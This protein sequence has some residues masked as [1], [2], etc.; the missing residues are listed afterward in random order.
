MIDNYERGN[1]IF[2]N[3][4]IKEEIK[5]KFIIFKRDVKK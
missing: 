3:N 5:V 1:K 4:F 2:G